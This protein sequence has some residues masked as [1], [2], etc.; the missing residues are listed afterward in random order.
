MLPERAAQIGPRRAPR[1]QQTETDADEQHRAGGESEHRPIEPHAVIEFA[2]RAAGRVRAF[3]TERDER[4]R[5][6]SRDEQSENRSERSQHQ[7]LDKTFANEPAAR[8]TERRAQR[9]LAIALDHAR[10]HQA[11]EICGGDEQ[12][13]KRGAGDEEKLRPQIP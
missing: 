1:G 11:G 8:R 7:R 6:P 3:G 4:G 2:D 13:A 9:H 5:E 12:R 10:Q